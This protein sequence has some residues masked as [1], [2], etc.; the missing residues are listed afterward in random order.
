[1]NLRFLETFVWV[2]RLKSFSLTADKLRTTQAGV[3]SRIATLER[4]LGVRLFE[5]DGREV[6]LTA[7]GMNALEDAEAIVRMVSA[8]RERIA[9]KECL[10]GTVRIGVIDTIAQ[11]WLMALIER[12]RE[13]YP[14]VAFELQADTSVD[15]AAKLVSNR[16]DLGLLM[17]PVIGRGIVNLDLCTYACVWVASPR[18]APPDGP[19][20]VR[21][22][23]AYP[24]ISF[25]ASSKPHEMMR[26]YFHRPGL[27]GVRLH[28][29]NSLATIVR[30]ACD[31]I[32]VAALPA[33]IIRDELAD[34]RLRRLD[35][36]QMFP[37]LALHASYVEAPNNPLPGVIAGMAD[38][39]ADAFCKEADPTLA[40]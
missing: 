11:S 9:A 2:A 6:R 5:R 1:M 8:F 22:L 40:W 15:I 17:G 18:L 33:V 25:P 39:V 28:T 37:P 12:S 3:S 19:V 30:M 21:D 31:G 16:L 14:S 20:E 32:G 24:I 26:H 23:A 38:E 10:R 29:S 34:G 35:V 4:E 7:E 27:E 13:R 36:R